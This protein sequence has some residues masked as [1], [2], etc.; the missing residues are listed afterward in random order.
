MSARRSPRL[1]YLLAVLLSSAGCAAA[2]VFGLL[3]IPVTSAQTAPA[4]SAPSPEEIARRRS[5]QSR[6]RTAVAFDAKNFY[7]FVGY[8]TGSRP[9]LPPV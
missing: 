7:R 2:M 1:A 3:A 6:P 8:C 5:E 9:A 4:A